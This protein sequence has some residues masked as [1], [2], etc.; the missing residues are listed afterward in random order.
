MI[1]TFLATASRTIAFILAL[2]LLATAAFAGTVPPKRKHRRATTAHKT[3]A[4]RQTVKPAKAPI[5]RAVA[6]RTP[7]RLAAVRVQKAV[8]AGPRPVA[9]AAPIIAGGPWTSPTY[10]DS[11]DGD[12]IDGEDLDIRHAAVDALG[13]Y[14]GSVVVV[15][16]SNGRV[17][18]M[19]NQKI[20]LSTGFQPCS[21]VK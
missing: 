19:V 10:A 21:T 14:N 15:D 4:A 18:T 12:N 5:K 8:V 6:A 1:R 20:A 2:Q 17:L 13:Q 9:P 11:T 3:P 7:V 16:P